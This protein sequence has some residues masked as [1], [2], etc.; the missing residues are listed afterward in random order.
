MEALSQHSN[1]HIRLPVELLQTIFS[2]TIDSSRFTIPEG[3]AG[4]QRVRITHV[5]SYWRAV[6]LQTPQLWDDIVIDIDSR[7]DV[8][9]IAATVL[10]RTSSSPKAITVMCKAYQHRAPK[11]PTARQFL[12]QLVLPFSNSIK[13]LRL[14]VPFPYITALLSS[15]TIEFPILE[16]LSISPA[17][18]GILTEPHLTPLGASSKL[19]L[20]RLTAVEISVP[21]RRTEIADAFLNT[22]QSSRLT[23]LAITS[24]LPVDVCFHILSDCTH[25]KACGI[26]LDR[27][28]NRQT[29]LNPKP[30]IVL[31]HLERFHIRYSSKTGFQTFLAHFVLPSIKDL[32]L[33]S[34]IDGFGW[35]R[36]MSEILLKR[37]GPSLEHLYIAS[38]AFC[39]NRFSLEGLDEVLDKYALT[40]QRLY[41][42]LTVTFEPSRLD[43]SEVRRLVSRDWCPNLRSLSLEYCS[44]MSER[45]AAVMDGV[46]EAEAHGRRPVEELLL[47][48]GYPEWGKSRTVSALGRKFKTF[49]VNCYQ[50]F[51]TFDSKA[52]EQEWFGYYG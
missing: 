49:D 9:S 23:T 42:P 19:K 15:H 31:P 10:S 18:Y 41:I 47:N 3:F 50:T 6:A 12:D 34:R 35:T 13:K 25:L 4:D 5:C 8:F 36:R 32:A 51:V 45:M 43:S 7:R 44:S 17:S 37:C 16:S 46:L 24:P 26:Y 1:A 28:E 48:V 22:V 39:H 29:Q 52:L 20:P 38:S 14:V 2:S 30:I 33:K 11:E 40:L 21:I 27:I